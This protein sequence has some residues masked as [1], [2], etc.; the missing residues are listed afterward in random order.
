M[1]YIGPQDW[2][3]LAS[4]S[5]FGQRNADNMIIIIA[6]AVGLYYL[7]SVRCLWRRLSCYA[8]PGHNC[9]ETGL[10]F[11]W[12][13]KQYK[14]TQSRG[15]FRRRKALKFVKKW[16]KLGFK[17]LVCSFVALNC[18]ETDRYV[19]CFTVKYKWVLV[20][21]F[22]CKQMM[23]DMTSWGHVTSCP[24]STGCKSV[25]VLNLHCSHWTI[26][27]HDFRFFC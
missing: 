24:T 20:N 8:R 17:K 3:K 10:L 2:E 18:V 12:I 15:Q 26:G 4:H 19:G 22:C 7:K 21:Y 11:P 1:R 27:L 6:Y 13:Q 16:M 9:G 23:W 14:H 25:Y 5:G